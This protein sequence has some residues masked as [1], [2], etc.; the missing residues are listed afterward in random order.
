MSLGILQN[1]IGP[2]LG[3]Y[4]G[5][6]SSTTAPRVSTQ[7][8]EETVVV[9]AVDLKYISQQVQG[10]GVDE[11]LRKLQ[12][13]DRD[14]RHLLSKN[15]ISGWEN[16]MAGQRRR[17]LQARVDRLEAEEAERVRVDRSWA[18]EESVR[19]TDAIARAKRLQYSETDMVKSFHSKVVLFE[20][21]KERDMQIEL[22]KQSEGE[23]AWRD[24]LQRDH[25][26][27]TRVAGEHRDLELMIE[28]R[29]KGLD[30][31]ATLVEQAREKRAREMAETKVSR[32]PCEERTHAFVPLDTN[33]SSRHCQDDPTLDNTLMTCPLTLLET[34]PSAAFALKRAQQGRFRAELDAMRADLRERAVAEREEDQRKQTTAEAWRERKKVQQEKKK[35]MEQERRLRSIKRKQQSGQEAAQKAAE[36]EAKVDAAVAKAMQDREERETRILAIEAAKRWKQGTDL[37]ESYHEHV[38]REEEAA[39]ARSAEEAAELQL[40]MAQQEQT[41]AERAAK[42]AEV[43][44]VGLELQDHHFQDMALHASQRQNQTVA[45]QSEARAL[46]ALHASQDLA[47][48]AYKRSVAAEPWAITNTRLQHHV[49]I[50]TADRPPITT[51]RTPNGGWL[52]T[53]RRLGFGTRVRVVEAQEPSGLG[54]SGGAGSGVVVVRPGK[55]PLSGTGSVG[56]P[57]GSRPQ[58]CARLVRGPGSRP[59]SSNSKSVGLGVQGLP[60][61]PSARA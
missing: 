45:S 22:K 30:V 58:S 31:Q 39:R 7:K 57:P 51:T 36:Q 54:S 14:R 25:E 34:D 42:K 46:H 9:S 26:R 10:E 4:P 23:E 49:E 44:R 56:T 48:K 18:A 47:L 3:F 32:K 28:A 11:R 33:M 6:Y 15:R 29:K 16:T 20:T 61:L 17:R 5:R 8:R 2:D 53:G 55:R 60:A 50:E 43:R 59:T 21:L 40:Y 27:A 24:S 1:N 19:R 37:A 35:A 52:D 13:E 12:K 41:M 38:A